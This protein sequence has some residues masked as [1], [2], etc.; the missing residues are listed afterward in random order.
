MALSYLERGLSIF[1]LARNTK[2]PPSGFLWRND[3][4]RDFTKANLWFG[5][6]SASNI[7][8]ATGDGL[9]VIDVDGDTGIGSWINLCL[10]H[11]YVPETYTVKTPNGGYHYYFEIPKGLKYKTHTGFLD[12]VDVRADGGYVV[13]PPS[14]LETGQYLPV[15]ID[16]EIL[17]LPQFLVDLL[18]LKDVA[19]TAPRH[20]P[21]TQGP[22]DVETGGRNSYIAKVVGVLHRRALC[23]DAVL[24]AAQAEN[25][26]K[27]S[28]PLETDEIITIVNSITRYASDQPF[29]TPSR[30]DKSILKAV[31]FLPDMLTYLSDKDRVTGLPTQIAGLDKLLGGGKRLGEVT[32]WHAEAKTGKNA[33]WHKMMHLWLK[34]DVPMGY[35]SR[36]LDPAEEV[37]PNLLSIEFKQNAWIV[38]P[39]AEAYRNA[40]SRWPLY[41]A[42]GD[43][44]FNI[45]LVGDWMRDLVRMGVHHFWFDHLHYMLDDPEEHKQA[46]KLCRDLRDLTKKLK[47]HTDIII[48]PN[49]LAE[50]QKLGLNSF[51]GGSAIA[52]LVNTG[53]VLTRDKDLPGTLNVKVDFSRNR[54]VKTGTIKLLYDFDTT[55]YVELEFQN[56]KSLEEKGI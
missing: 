30:A 2:I 27:C 52:Q 39:N 54:L 31:D 7:A 44:T 56:P 18:P 5:G 36:E 35:A 43:G 20:A 12:H 21:P 41:F 47:V 22:G 37:L 10:Q 49:K 19:N 48:Q 24:Q 55:D 1:P 14:K 50:G 53:I 40:L 3:N 51:K 45:E 32:A 11:D 34:S 28:P 42:P 25:E 26:N 33:L 13:A 4:T 8:I 15:L 9:L 38:E 6:T 23:Y 29:T 16:A 17:P 46:V